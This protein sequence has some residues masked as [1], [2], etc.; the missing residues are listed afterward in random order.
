MNRFFDSRFAAL[1]IVLAVSPAMAGDESTCPISIPKASL[2]GQETPST[3][4]WFGSDSL[5]AA[6]PHD[7][8]W[9]GMGPE[10]NYFNKLVWLAAG[11]RPGMESEFTI[12]GKR[13]DNDNDARKPLVSGVTNAFHDSFGGWTI[14]TGLGFPTTGCWEVTGSYQGQELTFVVRVENKE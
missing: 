14:M 4:R 12:T 10:R 11:F 5:A 3:L 13:L 1:L 2:H 9:H 7:G 6:I 8:I